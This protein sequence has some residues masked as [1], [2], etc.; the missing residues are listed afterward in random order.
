MKLV[1]LLVIVVGILILGF[2]AWITGGSATALFS[3][4]LILLM[5]AALLADKAGILTLPSFV[6]RLI[7]LAVAIC[8]IV[9]TW[10]IISS[11]WEAWKAEAKAT[12]RNMKN[13]TVCN[14]ENGDW[15]K[16]PDGH[17]K[18]TNGQCE[19][20][21][22]PPVS[23]NGKQGQQKQLYEFTPKGCVIVPIRNLGRVDFYP[24]GGKVQINPPVDAKPQAVPWTDEPGTKT[25]E[26]GDLP[27][28]DYRVCGL[29][30]NAWGIEVWN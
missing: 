15:V 2:L 4:V 19:K 18:D 21:T 17:Y 14:N 3:G 11:W 12:A 24:K 5:A 22:A 27:K 8:L 6:K 25:G 13:P 26:R 1:V 20:G 16:I 30:D 7:G 23:N 9:I 29:D 28:G 10:A